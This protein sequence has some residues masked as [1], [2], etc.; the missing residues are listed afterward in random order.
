M[1]LKYSY[2]QVKIGKSSTFRFSLV[3]I[4]GEDITGSNK[5][6][7]LGL[8]WQVG[9]ARER[10]RGREIEEKREREGPEERETDR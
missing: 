10:E 1:A 3:N 9:R 2:M 8:V 5:K 6:L 7:T 4:S